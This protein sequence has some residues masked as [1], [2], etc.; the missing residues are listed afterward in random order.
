MGI[1]LTAYGEGSSTWLNSSF[2][3]GPL[4]I[5]WYAI[6]ILTGASL[7]IWQCVREGKKIGVSTDDIYWLTLFALPLAIIGARLWYVIFNASDFHSFGEVLGFR[8]GKF[9]GLQGLGIQG[10][11]IAALITIYVVCRIRNINFYRVLDLLAP[12]ILIGQIFGRFGNFFNHELYGPEVTSQFGINFLKN[13]PILGTNMYIDGAFR[14]PVFLYEAL[15]NLC[16]VIFMLVMRR[17]FRKLRHGD[18]IGI[19][20][21]WYGSVRIFTES[22]RLNSGVSE[23]LMLGP[24]PVSIAISV[25]FVLLGSAFLVL[26]TFFGPK[27]RYLGLS[28]PVKDKNKFDIVIFDN[29]GTLID[30]KKL[31]FES[32]IHTFSK[33]RPDYILKDEELE[34]F[35]GPT[36]KQTFSRYAKDEEE[37][38]EMIAYYREFNEKMHDQMAKP[39]PGAKEMLENL[40]R[41][42]I[43]TAVVSSKKSNLLTHGLE[44]FGLLEYIDV[45]ISEDKVKNPKPDPEGILLA[46]KM[47]TSKEENKEEAPLENEIKED[48]IVE[49]KEEIETKEET[50]SNGEASQEEAV[51]E[52]QEDI[53]E[54]EEVK[55]DVTTVEETKEDETV[56]EK[57]ETKVE[58]KVTEEDTKDFD[59]SRVIYI[60][61]TKNDITAAK[62]AKVKS[63]GVLYIKNPEIMLECKPD[64]VVDNLSE[65]LKIVG[66]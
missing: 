59:L 54:F 65:V 12:G 5:A 52:A 6:F 29:D 62:A 14:H 58:E 8:N 23:P 49:N 56:V 17:K 36:L 43:K 35:F 51:I 47:L 24:I 7:G 46:V 34:T 42:G 25:L 55:E 18:L 2:S 31:I 16:G 10:G 38:N 4:T 1:F 30:S 48:T 19:Y 45:V 33:F 13:I 40:K 41:R 64:Y 32:F 20:L 3:I 27:E 15:L 44:V 21:I 61:D 26:K 37:L 39:F 63:C 50:P 11:I 53:K 22:L 57:E 66:E 60:G 9:I 28:N